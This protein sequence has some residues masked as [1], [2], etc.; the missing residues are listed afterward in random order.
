MT[1]KD[2]FLVLATLQANYPD[3]FRGMSQAAAD[4]KVN[5]W[6]EM[7]ADEPYQVVI[8]A[9]HAYISTDTGSFMPT[10]GQ[11]KDAIFRMKHPEQLSP[12][13]AWGMVSKALKNGYYG[14]DEEFQKLPEA[15]RL[16]VGSPGQLREW[17][18]MDVTTVQS[19][20]A[21]N[22]QKSF[23]VCQQRE[24]DAK[25]L[26][27]TVRSFVAQLADKMAFPELPDGTK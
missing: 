22:F 1:K 12:L 5:L 8:A 7:F 13:E 19:V 17:S 26:P 25:K 23:R 2:A 21:S 20:V 16:A 10:I 6:A 14:A 3:S 11:L 18:Q 24:N 9:V 27:S 15:V 4:A